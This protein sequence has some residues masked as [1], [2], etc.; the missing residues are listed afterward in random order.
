MNSMTILRCILIALCVLSANVA[1]GQRRI[2]PVDNP[3]NKK[4]AVEL[5]VVKDT[6]NGDTPVRPESVI[7]TRDMEGRIV[8]VDTISGVEYHD[9]I[10]VK[11]PRTIYP[12]FAAV[13]IG[14]NVWD[15]LARMAGQQYGLGGIWAE[16]SIHNWFKP[17][18]EIGVGK[19]DYMPKDESYRY[20]SGAAPYFKIGLNY[21]FLYNSTPD[22]S[23]YLGL[24]YG[25]SSFNYNVENAVANNSYWDENTVLSVPSQHATVGYFEVM[26]GLR[27]K[28]WRELFMG[29]EL[30]VHK[31][32]HQGSHAMGNPWYVP[33]YGTNGSLFAGAFSVSYTLPFS[34]SNQ[35]ELP[36]GAEE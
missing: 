27:V 30:K 4:K 32:L 5:P 7:E 36:P 13:T 3:D 28:I 11:A 12:R 35:K 14:V 10:T 2:T 24:R 23:V 25:I 15:A 34:K 19:A 21:N 26:V 20:L 16:L 29:W 8:L 33:G 17:I 6:K 31:I 1:M 9:T 18:I 22:Y